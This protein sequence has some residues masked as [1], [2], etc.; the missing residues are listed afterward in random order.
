MFFNIHIIMYILIF[1]STLYRGTQITPR[2][3][4][5][6]VMVDVSIVC[7]GFKSFLRRINNQVDRESNYEL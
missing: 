2:A 7:D 4:L 3:D 5:E 1:T 6:I